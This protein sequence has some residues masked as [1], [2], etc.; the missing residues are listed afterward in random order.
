[1]NEA[2][3]HMLFNHF[4]IIGSILCL[5]L[6]G[7]ALISKKQDIITAALGLLVLVA[8]LTIPAMLSGEGAEEI[9]EEMQ[10]VNHDQ[11]HEHEEMGEKA[12]ILLEISGALALISLIGYRMKSGF[13]RIAT[14]ATFV[15]LLGASVLMG[16]TGSEG[17]KIRHPELSGTTAA[18]ASGGEQEN[19]EDHD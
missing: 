13:T 12:F 5:L 6:L 19:G 4:P 11:I 1:M 9:V 7:Y 14:L 16:L 2:K 15:T 10:G 8:L 18:P 17:G 3:I